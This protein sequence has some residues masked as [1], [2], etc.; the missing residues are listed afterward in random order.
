[1]IEIDVINWIFY[2]NININ[3]KII[4]NH[5][6]TNDIIIIIYFNTIITLFKIY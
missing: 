2:C 3:V 1:M 4:S 6:W 5:C